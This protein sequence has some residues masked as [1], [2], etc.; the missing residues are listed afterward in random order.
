MKNQ[1]NGHVKT[2]RKKKQTSGQILSISILGFVLRMTQNLFNNLPVTIRT[3]IVTSTK[4]FIIFILFFLSFFT[5]KP[6]NCFIIVTINHDADDDNYADAD[7]AAA[8][9]DDDDDKEHHH[10]INLE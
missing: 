8:A 3:K 6:S 4:C 10:S 5:S 1:I 9:A 7:A 2:G